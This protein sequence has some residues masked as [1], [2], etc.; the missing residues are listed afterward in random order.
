MLAETALAHSDSTV[1]DVGCGF[2]DLYG[3]LKERGWCGRYT[4]IDIVPGLLST[5][6]ERNPEFDLEEETG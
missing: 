1:L 5:A 3:F 4:G 6:R 2:A